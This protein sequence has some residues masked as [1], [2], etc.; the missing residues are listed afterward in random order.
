[1]S[2]YLQIL[3]SLLEWVDALIDLRVHERFDISIVE[4]EKLFA[5]LK[6][7]AKNKGPFEKEWRK[8]K[9]A[10]EERWPPIFGIDEI[11]VV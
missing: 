5:A 6:I 1:M 9:G 3:D 4:D 10:V 11:K 7:S 8:I 2:L